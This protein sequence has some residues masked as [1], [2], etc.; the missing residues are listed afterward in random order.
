[1]PSL[2]GADRFTPFF[3][4]F[5][6][7]GPIDDGPGVPSAAGVAAFESDALSPLVFAGA[8]VAESEGEALTSLAGDSSLI[9]AGSKS[10]RSSSD[11][12]LS[13][14]TIVGLLPDLRRPSPEF[15]LGGAI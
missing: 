6:V 7:G 13:V 8:A 14:T 10:R 12:I 4:G 5:S 11:E 15:L 3:L 2:L 9:E 1:M